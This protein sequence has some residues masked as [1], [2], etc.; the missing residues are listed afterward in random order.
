MLFRSAFF[1]AV[2]RL[3]NA[4]FEYAAV[5]PVRRFGTGEEAFDETYPKIYA[6]AQCT[7]DLSAEDCRTCLTGISAQ[8]M[9]KSF[10]GKMGG[11]VLALR[12]NFRYETHSFFNGRSLVQLPFG[13]PPSST[14]QAVGGEF[15]LFELI[16]CR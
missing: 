8:F 16:F 7:P 9:R 1:A 6:L 15:F 3:V 10:F 12:C 4:T 14:P 13:P 2:S 5:D 11:R